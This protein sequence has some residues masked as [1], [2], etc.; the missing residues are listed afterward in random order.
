[1]RVRVSS[2]R[3]RLEAPVRVD[4]SLRPGTVFM[5]FHH[6]EQVATN[7]L[8]IDVSDPKSGTAELNASAVRLDPL[9][10]RAAGGG[11]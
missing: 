2:R 9:A 11:R 10:V 4:T 3:G 8:T 5:T 7:L 1:M 6:P